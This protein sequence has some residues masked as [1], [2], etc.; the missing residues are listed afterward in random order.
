[1]K[2]IVRNCLDQAWQHYPPALQATQGHV[3]WKD[4]VGASPSDGANM[5]VGVARLR[6]GETLEPH[7]HSEPETYFALAG[8][9]LV[10]V[11]GESIEATQGTTIYIPGD[12]LHGMENRHDEDFL[13]L[14]VFAVDDWAKV[15]YRF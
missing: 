5:L 4:M 14:Y 9:G 13:I 1:L 15:V 2:A 10:S 6:P 8:R 7:R 12:A 3:T 11:D